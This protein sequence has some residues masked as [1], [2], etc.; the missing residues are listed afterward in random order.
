MTPDDVAE[1]TP[2]QI[3][4]ADPLLPPT[5]LCLNSL[6]EVPKNLGQINT[7]PNDYQSDPMEISSTLWIP[8]IT[9]WWRYQEETHSMSVAFS[10]VARNIFWIIPYR[11]T[12][13]ASFSP[14]QDVTGCRQQKTASRTLD[15]KEVVMQFARANS[16]IVSGADPALDTMNTENHSEMKRQIVVSTFLRMA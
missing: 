10:N 8:D 6:T 15:K 1:T 9:D 2:W 11:V 14:G 5:S 16:T 4:R 13:D 7:N 12:V 3:D